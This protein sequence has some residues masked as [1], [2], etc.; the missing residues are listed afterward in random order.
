MVA[1][2]VVGRRF[3]DG[4]V[5]RR[6]T[7]WREQLLKLGL[8]RE[9]YDML[10]REAKHSVRR[11][12]VLEP[13]ITRMPQENYGKI[14]DTFVVWARF[15]DLFSYDETTCYLYRGALEDG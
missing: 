13:F 12:M 5:E 3:I 1:V 9:M 8:F 4:S 15:G 14:V 7:I 10:Q 2:A 11:E 6:K